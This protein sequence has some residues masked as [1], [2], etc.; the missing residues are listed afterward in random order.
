MPA[1]LKTGT[2][3]IGILVSNNRKIVASSALFKVVKIKEPLLEE[4]KA[5]VDGNYF[6]AALIILLLVIAI[7]WYAKKKS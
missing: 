3:V 1:R 4:P 6:L 2:Y 7:V 5:D